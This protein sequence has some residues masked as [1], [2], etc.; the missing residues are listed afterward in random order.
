MVL[1]ASALASARE[2]AFRLA[3]LRDALQTSKADRGD[4]DE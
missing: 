4:N 1:R 3:E 2:A